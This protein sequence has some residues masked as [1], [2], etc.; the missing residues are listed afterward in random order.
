MNPPR[1]V[2]SLLVAL[3][4]CGLASCEHRHRSERFSLKGGERIVFLGDSI[5]QAGLYVSYLDA[6]LL[7]RF[8]DKRFTLLNHGR[9]GETV[10]GTREAGSGVSRPNAMRRFARDVML[11]QPDVVVAGFGMNDGSYRPFDERRFVKFKDGVHS[12]IDRTRNEA[13]ASLVLLTPPPFDPYRRLVTDDHAKE[14]G[15]RFPAIDYDETLKQY[16]RWLLTLDPRDVVVADAHTTM[17]DHLRRRRE[18]DVSF[19]LS[20]DAVHPNATGHWLIAQSLLLAWKAPALVAEAKINAKTLK[21]DSDEVRDIRL[22]G[23]DLVATWRTGL[24]MPVDPAWDQRSIELEQVSERLNRYRLTVTGLPAP[25]YTLRARLS[26]AEEESVAGIFTREQLAAG[27]DLTKLATFPTVV[28]SNRVLELVLEHR[29]REDRRWREQLDRPTGGDFA[30]LVPEDDDPVLA[31]IRELC[32]PRDL[33]LRL[34]P[35]GAAPG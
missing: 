9:N 20:E 6:Y 17:T 29:S 31:K 24:P 10:S 19:F 28:L 27:L 22:A 32:R 26:D 5:T 14:F 16:S 34:S 7:T 2:L 3:L 33:C 1:S 11:W 13:H 23:D 30:S 15:Y 8:P 25:R 18:G 12:L 4:A 35:L 21:A